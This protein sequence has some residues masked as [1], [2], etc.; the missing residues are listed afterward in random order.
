M[1]EDA[2]ESRF[3]DSVPVS[4]VDD[5]SSPSVSIPVSVDQTNEFGTAIPISGEDDPLSRPAPPTIPEELPTGLGIFSQGLDILNKRLDET[6][7]SDLVS[8]VDSGRQRLSERGDP[9]E[10][11][12]TEEPESLDSEDEPLLEPEDKP[13]PDLETIRQREAVVENAQT[14]SQ[15]TSFNVQGIVRNLEPAFTADGTLKNANELR[16]RLGRL[17]EIGVQHV[18]SDQFALTSDNVDQILD[19]AFNSLALG[20]NLSNSE[21][22]ILKESAQELKTEVQFGQTFLPFEQQST[23]RRSKRSR[24]QAESDL[25]DSFSPTRSPPA[26][27]QR[28]DE[29]ERKSFV[30][31]PS[32]PFVGTSD[33]IPLVQLRTEEEFEDRP[34]S[35]RIDRSVFNVSVIPREREQ[36][37]FPEFPPRRSERFPR[38]QGHIGA[39]PVFE[40]REGPLERGLVR[41]FPTEQTAADAQDAINLEFQRVDDTEEAVRGLRGELQRADLTIADLVELRDD[42]ARDDPRFSD[43]LVEIVDQAIQN[44]PQIFTRVREGNR[45]LDPATR[46]EIVNVVT[47]HIRNFTRQA[48]METRNP[49][50]RLDLKRR[51]FGSID[52]VNAILA[53]QG[54]RSGEEGVRVQIGDPTGDTITQGI[55][56][57]KDL[58]GLLDSDK[59][60]DF[61]PKLGSLPMSSADFISSFVRDLDQPNRQFPSG[62]EEPMIT[63]PKSVQSFG[64][65]QLRKLNKDT[66]IVFNGLTQISDIMRLAVALTKTKGQLKF[67]DDILDI[68][69][70]TDVSR[71]IDFLAMIHMRHLGQT[72]RVLYTAVSM[73]PFV[74]G[75]LQKLMKGPMNI[76]GTLSQRRIRQRYL[77]L[78][79][80]AMVGGSFLSTL[81]AIGGILAPFV[82]LLL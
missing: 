53:R 27:R 18:R 22:H 55:Q 66:E 54:V 24:H 58:V 33:P 14:I 64:T 13:T 2:S 71:V 74:G 65:I 43:T 7:I 67:M 9:R 1:S 46:K 49:S 15:P 48:L 76:N 34:E 72:T 42:V 12:P 11:T 36:L 35:E 60:V 81:G 44:A 80:N 40:P 78:P 82:P 57:L 70:S 45:A 79:M 17:V 62:R 39:T 6:Q 31:I 77:Q 63:H 68:T 59:Q 61:E 52:T 5:P 21:L 75:S 23:P 4:G 51:I 20:M 10:P 50:E 3:V 25:N 16:N 19:A 41:V 28:F 38:P 8:R 47:D 26:Q 56:K 32:Q 37:I 30:P 73:N 29:E 69:P